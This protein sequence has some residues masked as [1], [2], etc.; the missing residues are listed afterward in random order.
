MQLIKIAGVALALLMVTGTAAAMPGAAPAQA[1]ENT[2][3]ANAT[4]AAEDRAQSG[5]AADATDRGADRS[6]S[7]AGDADRGP[8][9]DFPSQVPDFVGDIHDRIGQFLDGDLAGPLGERLSE[10]TPGDADNETTDTPETAAT[11]TTQADA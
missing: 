3:D 2:D 5:S 4:E 7:A 8:P 6:E 9:A 1:D 10:L 11:P